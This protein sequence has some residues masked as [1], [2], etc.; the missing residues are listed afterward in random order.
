MSLVQARKE[1]NGKTVHA[2]QSTVVGHGNTVLGPQNKVHGNKNTVLGPRCKVYGN[3]NIVQGPQCKVFGDDNEVTGPSCKATG[4]RNR[5]LGPDSKQRRVGGVVKKKKTRGM[6]ITGTNMTGLM[7]MVSGTFGSLSQVGNACGCTFEMHEGSNT[8][9]GNADDVTVVLRDKK[10]EKELAVRKLA[11]SAGFSL[12][13]LTFSCDDVQVK[14]GTVSYRGEPVPL[15]LFTLC[16][17]VEWEELK[18]LVRLILQDARFIEGEDRETDDEAK[19]CVVCKENEK[20]CLLV[21][22]GH[23]ALCIKCANERLSRVGADGKDES[24]EEACP[25]CRRPVERVVRAFG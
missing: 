4:E 8:Q 22:C 24:R 5:V 2:T 12:T 1:C 14:D 19:E 9:V 23:I 3:E 25:V 16:P 10:G 21:P 7:K 15:D 20:Q 6:V 17:E 13:G 18:N 11:S